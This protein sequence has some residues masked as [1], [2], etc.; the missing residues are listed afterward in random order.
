MS[1]NLDDSPRIRVLV[2]DDSAFM[3]TALAR[4]VN[5]EP[6]MEVVATASCASVALEK[7]PSLDPD[8][9]TLDVNMPGLDGLGTLRCIMHQFPRPVIMVSAVTEKD[10]E[11]TLEALSAGAFD[12]VPKQMS[13]TSLE[14]AHI[15]NELISKI[16]AAAQSRRSRFGPVEDRKPPQSARLELGKSVSAA[17][18]IVAIGVS[19]GGPKALEQ[20]LPM[21][22]PNFPVPI[23]IVQH[24]PVGFTATL[25]QRLN[26]ICPINVK[27]AAQGELI[28][29]GAAYIAPAGVHM[30]VVP[31]LS[32]SKPVIGLDVHPQDAMH[33]PSVDVLMNSVAEVFKHRALA[34]IMTGM[35]SDGAAG[36]TAIFRQGGLTF[37]QDEASCAVYG[38]PR[39]CA[40]LGVLTHVLSL[41]DIPAHVIHATRRRRRA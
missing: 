40:Q 14:I 7:I 23:L 20:I 38:M 29:P 32:D 31:R 3:R 15:R 27:E 18:A 25:A 19:T 1:L 11:T 35:G 13:Q 34:V 39:V 2:V 36:M 22:P 30:R 28:R 5:C 10:A 16:R 41:S 26:S 21:F 12:Y 9:V 4:M 33:I 8:V 24:M 17:P 37:G 6:D